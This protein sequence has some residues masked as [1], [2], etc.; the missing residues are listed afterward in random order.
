MRPCL[1]AAEGREEPPLALWA[2]P[3]TAPWAGPLKATWGIWA[4]GGPGLTPA[5]PHLPP[6]RAHTPSR[7]EAQQENFQDPRSKHLSLSWPLP[8]FCAPPGPP[9]PS[10]GPSAVSPQ[11]L[12]SQCPRC[13]V[14]RRGR[15]E[16]LPGHPVVSAGPSRG[17]L[18]RGAGK[19]AAA[20]PGS[21]GLASLQL[22]RS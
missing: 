9:P 21:P 4:G 7:W 11:P 18:C 15:T 8:H 5:C 14:T 19:G 1:G 12:T 22:G 6:G 20:S 17:R 16:A 13:P 2:P 10:R 3:P